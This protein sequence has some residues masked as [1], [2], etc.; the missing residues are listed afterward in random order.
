VAAAQPDDFIIASGKLHTVGQFVA[1]AF[2][3]AGLAWQPHVVEDLSLIKT[4]QLGQ[5]LVGD[6]SRLRKETGWRPTLSFQEMVGQMVDAE[7]R[8]RQAAPA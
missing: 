1:T 6:N 3:A 4:A 8:S 7:L 2:S 5:A